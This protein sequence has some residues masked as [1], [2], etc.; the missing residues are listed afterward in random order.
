MRLAQKPSALIGQVLTDPLATGLTVLAVTDPVVIAHIHQ[1]QIA[2]LAQKLNVLIG[3]VVTARVATDLTKENQKM[4]LAQKPNVLIA[5]VVI[6]LLATENLMLKKKVRQPLRPFTTRKAVPPRPDQEAAGHI[7]LT[8]TLQ[9]GAAVRV[10]PDQAR[11]TRR[12]PSNA[13]SPRR[14]NG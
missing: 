9:A 12:Y 8:G 7:H 6:V 4:R 3:P 5:R 14:I 10:L 11:I 2:Q 13:P 1:E